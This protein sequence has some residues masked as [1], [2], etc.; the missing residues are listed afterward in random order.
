MY[1]LLCRYQRQKKKMTTTMFN[2]IEKS[3]YDLITSRYDKFLENMADPQ[4][5]VVRVFDPLPKKNLEELELIRE[6]TKELQKKKDDD[7]KKASAQATN[8]DVQAE[9]KS[10]EQS[11][12]NAAE[13]TSK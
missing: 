1:V 8:G 4:K 9:K 6:V 10:P 3:R 7:M 11:E 13:Q 2:N 12:P 5:E